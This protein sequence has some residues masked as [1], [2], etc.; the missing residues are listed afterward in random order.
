MTHESIHADR[1]RQLA[2]KYGTH[3]VI[4]SDTLHTL[5]MLK[6]FA[7]EHDKSGKYALLVDSAVMNI[8]RIIEP[9]PPLLRLDQLTPCGHELLEHLRQSTFA[10]VISKDL[11]AKVKGAGSTRREV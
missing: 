8:S 6:A 7:N 2:T 9:N 11:L 10:E 3:T 4:L 1:L 5:S